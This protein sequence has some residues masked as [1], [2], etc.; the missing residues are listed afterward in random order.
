VLRRHRVLIHPLARV[1]QLA[2]HIC[3]DVCD[4]HVNGITSG[5]QHALT[6]DLQF[7]LA[8]GNLILEGIEVA[9]L[10]YCR[11]QVLQ[12][13]L[14]HRFALAVLIQMARHVS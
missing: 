2:S 11:P 7:R 14:Q 3:S 5:C 1:H 10:G 12:L 9:A 4:L 6:D 8:L 13:S